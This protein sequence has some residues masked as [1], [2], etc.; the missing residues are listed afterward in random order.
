MKSEA[1]KSFK[2]AERWREEA[3]R[4]RAILLDCGLTEELKWGKPCYTADGKNVV[5]IQRMKDFLALLFFKGALLRDPD[6]ILEKPGSNSRVGRRVRFSGVDDVTG[7]EATLKAYIREAVAVEKAGLKVSKATELDLPEEL[8]DRFGKDPAL[9]TA[10]NALTPGRQRGY[11]L[12]FSAAKR[13]ETRA[14]RIEK[15]RRKILDGKG[16]HDR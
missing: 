13:S 7:L 8:Q 1:D 3:E 14:A 15:Y 9:K 6:G 11:A 16:F 4:L 5:L 10:F 12:Y 2:N